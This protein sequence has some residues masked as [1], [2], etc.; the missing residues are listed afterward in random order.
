MS[1]FARVRA[2]A[3]L[4]QRTQKDTPMPKS[5]KPAG[6]R[7]Q[8][9]E[10]RYGKKTSYQDAKRRPGQSSAGT[11]GSKSPG[12]RGYRAE[13]EDTGRKNRW[14][15][16]ERAGR[17]EARGIRSQARDD[18]G[19]RGERSRAILSQRGVGYAVVDQPAYLSGHWASYTGLFLRRYGG[20]IRDFANNQKLKGELACEPIWGSTPSAELKLPPELADPKLARNTAAA[21]APTNNACA[22]LSVPK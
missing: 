7:A 20:C 2:G 18:R 21:A 17:D 10:P 22:R 6:G 5:K 11:P 9:F 14:S 12:H 4:V 1:G 19:G 13:S 16:Q 3:V 8:N 15:S